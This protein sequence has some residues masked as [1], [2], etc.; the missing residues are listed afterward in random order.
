MQATNSLYSGFEERATIVPC[1]DAAFA[2]NADQ[3]SRKTGLSARPPAVDHR[4]R[5]EA[6]SLNG[7]DVASLCSARRRREF[8]M[9]IPLAILARDLETNK[10]VGGLLG[11]TVIGS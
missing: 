9:D 2:R 7:Y 11:R 3:G 5:R 1:P 8:G 4:R 10:V 6:L